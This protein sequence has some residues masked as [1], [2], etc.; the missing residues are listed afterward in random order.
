MDIQ[1]KPNILNKYDN[2]EKDGIND[3]EDLEEF[4]I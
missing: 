4:I 1:T 2:D 3:Y